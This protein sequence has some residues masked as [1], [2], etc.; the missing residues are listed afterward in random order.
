MPTAQQNFREFGLFLQLATRYNVPSL[1]HHHDKAH[2]NEQVSDLFT[3][4][5]KITHFAC[6]FSRYVMSA[7]LSHKSV[8]LWNGACDSYDGQHL[9]F[10]S[11]FWL[12]HGGICITFVLC[13]TTRVVCSLWDQNCQV[14]WLVRWEKCHQPCGPWNAYNRCACTPVSF[15]IVRRVQS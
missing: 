11:S 5:T 1:S 12:W 4:G 2:R 6:H 13:W 14:W 8:R 3:D 9:L 10:F 15:Y 7:S